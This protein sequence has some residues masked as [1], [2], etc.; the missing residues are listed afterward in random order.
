MIKYNYFYVYYFGSSKIKDQVW[1]MIMSSI[2]FI[3]K[4]NN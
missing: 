1:K 3:N 2:F 4:T